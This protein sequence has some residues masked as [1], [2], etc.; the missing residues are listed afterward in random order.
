[1]APYHALMAAL[2]TS[3]IS[4]NTNP[5]I[6]ATMERLRSTYESGATRSLDWREA[7]I[8][9]V[10]RFAKD[11][12]EGLLEAM[13][14][15]LGR[16]QTEGWIADVGATISEAEYVKKR[17]RKWASPR[18]A[19]LPLVLQP[20]SARIVP[21]PLG[22]ALIISPWNYPVNLVLE[23]MVAAFAAGNVVVAKPSELSPATS[24]L[25]A[26]HL[27]SYVDDGALAIFE[28]GP[29]VS[30]ELLAQ[31]FD[32]IFFSGSTHVGRI[33]MEAAAKN[34]TPVVLELGGK[35]P[36]IVADDADIEVSANRIAWGKGLNAGQTCIAPDYVLV[37]QKNRDALVEA[38]GAAWT[39]FYGDDPQ[40]SP[41]F[42]RIVSN[43]HHRR[44]VG[45][46]DGHTVVFGGEH[47]EDSK[48]LAPTM[49]IDPALDSPVSNEEIFGPILPIIT[50]D[51]VDAAIRYVNDR[52]KPL[53]LYVFSKSKETVDRVLDRTSSGGAC[54]NHTMMHFAPPELPFGGVG[55]S[56]MGSYHGK[57]G[58]DAYSNLKGVLRK[59]MAGENQLAYP[60]Y[61]GRK[62]RFL[63]KI[64]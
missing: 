54:V 23:P 51:D 22:V 11:H 61:S 20:G 12:T 27:P 21:E 62:S 46:L 15:D 2:T 6:S 10:I 57:F 44:L 38:I 13:Q 5:L 19:K 17:F 64:T 43:R 52:P 16:P 18:R 42:S 25:I 53:A 35:S 9:G 36:V 58:F 4:E 56:G 40:D 34:L 28:G 33:V 49:V 60:P 41:D 31:R 8:D 29:E 37:T 45:L 7:Q 47:D 1:M 14:S 39:S 32:H 50:I 55:A 24:G 59:P 48:Y 3:P 30:T 26:Q 63:R